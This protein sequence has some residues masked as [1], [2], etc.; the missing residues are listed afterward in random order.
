MV[1]MII[2]IIIAI[3]IMMKIRI[4]V[5]VVFEREIFV[6]IGTMRCKGEAKTNARLYDKSI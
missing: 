5:I 1:I 3:V 6:L 4:I 2:I